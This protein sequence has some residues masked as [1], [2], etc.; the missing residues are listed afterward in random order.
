MNASEFISALAAAAP[1]VEE[2]TKA[3]LSSKEAICFRRRYLCQQRKVPLGINESN[4]LFALMNQWNS[5]TIEIGMVCLADAPERTS[6]GMKIGVVEADPLVIYAEGE[7]A[8]H[9]LGAPEHI[10]WAV[11]ESPKGFLTALA[12]VPK[13]LADRSVD[14]ID[15]EDF[16]AAKV[17]A[18]QCASAAGGMRYIEFYSMLVGANG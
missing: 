3:G 7:L 6:Q 14:K 16:A 17:I 12:I 9:E 10:L 5:G 18:K 1:S 13:F 8:V 4:E 2:Y 11:A 15:F